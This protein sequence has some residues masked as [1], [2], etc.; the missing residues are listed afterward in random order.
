M[1]NGPGSPELISSVGH[2]AAYGG[3]GSGNAKVYGDPS[4]NKLL[5]GSSGGASDSEGAGAGG[6]A[7]LLKAARE[8]IIEPNVLIT[9]NGGNGDGNGASGSGGGVRLEATRIFNFG[10][11]EAKAGSG[12]QVDG[13]HQ[14]RGSSGGRV[15]IIASAEVTVGDVDVS[16]EWLSN[17]GSIFIGGNYQNS[18]L[19]ADN[20]KVTIDTETGYFSI[21][22]GAHG[23]GVFSNHSYTDSIGQNW[24]YGICSFT[25][26]QGQVK[27]KY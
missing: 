27:R 25:F 2:G 3:H 12:V 9:A 13:N 11:I 4:L 6:G 26:G 14:N 22:G 16:G 1:G 21:D 8:L 24:D 17:E 19:I 7:I 23:V 15:A 18:S 5:G 10:R 20:A